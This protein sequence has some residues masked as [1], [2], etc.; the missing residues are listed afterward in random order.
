MRG[1]I[2]VFTTGESLKRACVAMNLQISMAHDGII[3]KIFIVAR[4]GDDS[5]PIY[6]TFAT[7]EILITIVTGRETLL[8]NELCGAEKA[9]CPEG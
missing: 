8:K 4:C 1:E 2:F 9:D 5:L 7:E 6:Y 3:I